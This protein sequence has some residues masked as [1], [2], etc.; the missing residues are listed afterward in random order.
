V[1]RRAW[2][3][4]QNILNTKSYAELIEWLKTRS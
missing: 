3:E 4:P 2:C 1:A